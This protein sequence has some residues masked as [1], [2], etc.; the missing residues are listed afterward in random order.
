MPEH[1]R[2][3]VVILAISSVVF[4]FAK[5]PITSLACSERDFVRRRNLWFA[6]TLTAFLAHNFWLFVIVA[7]C[8]LAVAVRS[9]TNRFALYMGLVLALPSLS[10]S[11]P[12]FGLAT[13]LFK[14]SGLRL[15]ALVVLLPA[16]LALRKQ[17]GVEPFGKFLCDKLLLCFLGLEFLLA[18]PYLTVT[19]LLREYVLYAFID[20]FLVYYVAS[21]SLSTVKAFR[22]AL[23]AFTV[24]A[25][26]FSAIIAFE[27]W[28]GW[29]LYSAVDEALGAVEFNATYLRRAGLLRA[30]ATSGQAIV[31]GY[32][33]AIA[34]G[35]YMYIRTLVPNAAWRHLGMLLL[36]VGL[37]GA[38]SRAPWLGAASMM[39]VFVLLGSAPVA[40]IA[41]L[42]MAGLA[43]L[44]LLLMT[45][46][47]AFI[48]DLLPWIGSVEARNV[49][50]REHLAVVAMQV[51]L[52]SPFFGRYD[53]AAV[54]AIEALRG[55]DGVIDLVNTYVIVALR[56]GGVLLALF[57]GFA[58]VAIW[59]I[60][61]G[62]RKIGDTRDER[63]VLGRALL[64]TLLGV[65]LI[66]GTVSPIFFVYPLFWS[67]AGLAVGYMRLAE[68][69]EARAVS[70][71]LRA[72]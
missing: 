3:L 40:S 57:V 60:F 30:V 35:L 28:Q 10:A 16:Y 32:T 37:L 41:K 45:D 8:A 51:I 19:I 20:T 72:R 55:N 29:L 15:L 67:L 62:M 63:H 54:P 13:E 6:L 39:V 21:R 50:A 43:M 24:G 1:L 23:G 44:P 9:E 71:A 61:T 34:I 25:M 14:V 48:I 12:A 27:F 49:D 59:G 69:G 56:G 38:V 47:G 7:A 11:I 42:T 66:I 64:A 17:P 52:D 36:V 31:A 22:D 46:A 65:L 53:F 5:A 33:C 58:A 70:R 2:A 26:V 4:A 18:L 68:H